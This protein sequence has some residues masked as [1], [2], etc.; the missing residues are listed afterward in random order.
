LAVGTN[1]STYTALAGDVGKLIFCIITANNASGSTTATSNTVG[2]ITAGTVRAV[3]SSAGWVGTSG[4]STPAGAVAGDVLEVFVLSVGATQNVAGWTKRS[5]DV[6]PSA[7]ITITLF[8][9][10]AAGGAESFH[11][12]SDMSTFSGVCLAKMKTS[13]DTSAGL[14]GGGPGTSA[15]SASVTAATSSDVGSAAWGAVG[16]AS[17][18]V[19]STLALAASVALGSTGVMSVGYKQ[20]SASGSWAPGNATIGASEDYCEVSSLAQ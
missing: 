3:S 13:F 9:K 10:I 15:S 12:P 7:S 6:D 17:V 20:L 8:T 16:T 11:F 14:G 1:S 5:Q 4:F 18:T 2:P 19:P